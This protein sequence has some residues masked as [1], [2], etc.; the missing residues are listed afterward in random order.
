MNEDDLNVS[1]RKFLKQV[2]V[3][4][5]REIERAVTRALDAGEIQGN[6]QF[7]A[8]M[9]LEVAGLRLKTQFDGKIVLERG[10]DAK[11]E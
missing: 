4:S 8:T 10:E 3:L 11:D 5:Q 7:P 2:G 6:E 9:T 1:I